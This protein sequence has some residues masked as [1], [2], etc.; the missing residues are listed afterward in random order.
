LATLLGHLQHETGSTL[1]VAPDS[2][3]YPRIIVGVDSGRFMAMALISSDELYDRVGDP[4]APGVV[5]L[6]LGGQSV[7]DVPRRLV[8]SRAQAE[9]AL[10]EFVTAGNRPVSNDWIR[11]RGRLNGSTQ[12]PMDS[13]KTDGACEKGV[14]HCLGLVMG[15]PGGK[16]PSGQLPNV[17]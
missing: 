4:T 5:E 6:I 13:R 12:H 3:E 14:G 11:Q 9:K 2:G 15:A 7:D 8:L 17:P 10:E 1:E 16:D